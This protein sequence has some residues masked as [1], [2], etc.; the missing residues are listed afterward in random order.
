MTGSV[1]ASSETTTGLFTGASRRARQI[2]ATSSLRC[3]EWWNH[4]QSQMA[5]MHLLPSP[6]VRNRRVGK[7][8]LAPCPPSTDSATEAV[9][10]LRFA[11]PTILWSRKSLRRGLPERRDDGIDDVLDQDAILALAHD[12]DH[13]LGAGGAD[14]QAAVA[15]E[16]LLAI[17]DRRFDIGIV[18]RLAALV[19]D[20]LQDLRQ[21]IEA[22]ADFRHR[23]AQLLHDRQHMQCG[24]EAIAGGGVVGQDDVAGLLATEIVAAVQHLLEHVAIADRRAHEI[25]A[26]RIEEALE[27]EI[28]HHCGD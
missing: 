21:R 26:L 8:A 16:P 17:G 13:R 22:G 28:R 5:A 9:G 20:V 6:R 7:G 24:N 14:Q 10:T 3:R 19:T 27:P 1:S 11:H 2:A 25:K 18:E 4:R 15:V 12:A 23:P